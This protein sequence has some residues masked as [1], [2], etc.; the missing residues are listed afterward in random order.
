M[1]I[2]KAAKPCQNKDSDVE[3]MGN[4]AHKWNLQ[5]MLDAVDQYLAES[6]KQHFSLYQELHTGA[7]LALA[8]LYYAELACVAC[9]YLQQP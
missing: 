2:S 8:K 6:F 7:A 9:L 3:A 4:F 5:Q 1:F